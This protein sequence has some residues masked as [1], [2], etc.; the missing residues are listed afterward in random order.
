MQGKG[1]QYLNFFNKGIFE[2]TQIKDHNEHCAEERIR[3]YHNVS[4]ARRK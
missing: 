1:Q 3:H 2:S 4:E